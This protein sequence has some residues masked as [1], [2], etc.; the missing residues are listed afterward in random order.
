MRASRKTIVAWCAAGALFLFFT[1]VVVMV[2][3]LGSRAGQSYRWVCRDSGA[4]LTY[5][6][7]TFGSARLIPGRAIPERTHRWEL[8]EPRPLPAH[9]P[10]NWLA[11]LVS[12][13]ELDANA[14][15]QQENLKL[16]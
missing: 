14:V 7:S 13:R 5:S 6:P 16:N 10:W 8:I 11:L 9:M 4:E 15:M 3:Y 12:P 1:N 2:R